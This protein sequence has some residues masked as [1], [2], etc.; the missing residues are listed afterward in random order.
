MLFLWR[1]GQNYDGYDIETLEKLAEGGD[2]LAVQALAEVNMRKG[3]DKGLNVYKKAAVRGSTEAL[4]LIAASI[5]GVKYNNAADPE[6]KKAAL[7]ESLAWFNVAALRGDRQSLLNEMTLLQYKGVSIEDF[8][9]AQAQAQTQAQE[10]YNEL[11]KERTALG[12]G[13]F[14]NSVPPEVKAYFDDIEEIVHKTYK[15]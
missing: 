13:D 9:Q 5:Q 11:Q 10:I 2:G 4:A 8:A 6:A 15:P 3:F 12:L 14:D 1:G 7:I